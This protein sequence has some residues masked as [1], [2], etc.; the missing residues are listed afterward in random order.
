MDRSQLFICFASTVVCTA[1]ALKARV[2]ISP[3]N[4]PLLCFHCLYSCYHVLIPISIL[5][6]EFLHV[7]TLTSLC[8]H[9]LS[10]LSTT[11]TNNV[12]VCMARHEEGRG[13]SRGGSLVSNELTP[14]LQDSLHVLFLCYSQTS[15]C[16]SASLVNEPPLPKLLDPP[17]KGHMSSMLALCHCLRLD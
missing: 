11:S 16:H 3:P 17:L 5:L 2:R 12:I 8:M 7:S 14:L 6:K 13:G 15:T 1:L 10:V 4:Y 9:A